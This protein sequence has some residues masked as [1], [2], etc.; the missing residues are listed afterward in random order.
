[1]LPTWVLF[2]LFAEL[3]WVAGNIFDK[4]LLE[5]YFGEDEEGGPGALLIF[6]SY[7]SLVFVLGISLL[8]FDKIDFSLSAGLFGILVGLCN[9][10]WILLYLYALNRADLSQVIP[11]FQTIPIF[12]LLFGYIFLQ[13]TIT[14]AQGSAA[15]VIIFGAL[16]LLLSKKHGVLR[17]D[18]TTLVLMISASATV[19]CTES[20][21]KLV[22]LDINYWSAAFWM[23]LGFSIFGISLYILVPKLKKEFTKLIR[24]KKKHVLRMNSVNELFDNF[25]ELIFLSAVVLG[26]IALVQSI[27]A[28]QP[29]LILLAGAMA[30]IWI[31]KYFDEDL[32]KNSLFQKAVGI[33]IITLGSIFFYHVI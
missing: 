29:L 31:P 25:A 3:L 22:A 19:A 20:L 23:S 7:F 2:A 11:L 6:S 10:L 13:E 24:N 17:M 33:L 5:H 32:S 28:Y 8:S 15:A 26:P 4:Y 27:N 18:T 21:F 30:T 1:M 9:G 12:G 16:I 14:V